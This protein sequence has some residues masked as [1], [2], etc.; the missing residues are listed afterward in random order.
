MLFSA[1][2]PMYRNMLSNYFFGYLD[3]KQPMP[4][5]VCAYMCA[6]VYFGPS[7]TS[8]ARGDI[9]T[10]MCAYVCF[11]P[12]ATSPA[13][14]VICKIPVRNHICTLPFFRFRSQPPPPL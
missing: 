5:S 7:A 14:G 1:A 13:R 10:P 12:S 3:L 2:Q 9:V 11:G 8:P 4:Q 6:Y